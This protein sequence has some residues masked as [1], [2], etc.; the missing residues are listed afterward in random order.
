MQGNARYWVPNCCNSSLFPTPL[1]VPPSPHLPL[2]VAVRHYLRLLAIIR[3]IRDYLHYSHYALC[4]TICGSRRFIICYSGFPDW[5]YRAGLFK[6]ACLSLRRRLA[7]IYPLKNK[8]VKQILRWA[9][10]VISSTKQRQFETV[11]TPMTWI[12]WDHGR[13]PCNK[14]FGIFAGRM[15]RVRPRTRG[16]VLC[17]TGHAGWNFVVFENGGLF[18][19]FRGYRAAW[20]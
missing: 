12:I 2:F 16:H 5:P 20:L 11:T 7:Q 10:W 14:N 18:E 17:N 8:L 1:L 6:Y 13:F 4:A 15:E 19:T 3:F 9:S